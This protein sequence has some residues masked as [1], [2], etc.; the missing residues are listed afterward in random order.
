MAEDTR[1]AA[2]CAR[3]LTPDGGILTP[4][5]IDCRTPGSA[6]S[7]C[8][9]WAIL[10]SL[11]TPDGMRHLYVPRQCVKVECSKFVTTFQG[12]SPHVTV[13]QHH[14]KIP[15]FRHFPKAARPYSTRFASRSR[16][17]AVPG[18]RCTPVS[19]RGWVAPRARTHVG[20]GATRG[21][22]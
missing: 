22:R 20:H 7:P 11:G 9:V 19:R 3:I 15:P 17:G 12:P 18:L 1:F 10:H 5:G 21:A 6:P 14:G 2:S 13:V 8:R 4:D 16:A